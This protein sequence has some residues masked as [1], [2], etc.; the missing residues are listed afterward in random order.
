LLEDLW[1]A[2]KRREHDV[3]SLRE[4]VKATARLFGQCCLTGADLGR[5]PDADRRAHFPYWQVTH[6]R[7]A[8]AFRILRG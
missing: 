8:P 6:L 4:Y 3:V 2:G 1:S 5:D 7:F